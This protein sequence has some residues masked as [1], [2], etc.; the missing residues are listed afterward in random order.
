M[1][2]QSTERATSLRASSEKKFLNQKTLLLG[3]E[4]LR[5][6]RFPQKLTQM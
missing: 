4:A 5:E 2:I 1:Y 6:H 3:Q